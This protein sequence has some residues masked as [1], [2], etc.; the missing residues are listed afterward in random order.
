MIRRFPHEGD[1]GRIMVGFGEARLIQHLDTRVE[2]L[3]GTDADR[4]AALEWQ[5]R[6]L[7][8]A[9]LG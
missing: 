8:E 3:G 4:T 7:P 9:G 5:R 2:L 6:F 1:P